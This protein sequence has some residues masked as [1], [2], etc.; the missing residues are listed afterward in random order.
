[1]DEFAIRKT[2]ADQL[3]K[4]IARNGWSICA[5]ADFMKI[6][7]NELSGILNQKKDVQLSTLSRIAAGVGRPITALICPDAAQHFDNAEII[8]RVYVDLGRLQKGGAA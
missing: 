8:R 1:M 2:L 7:R 6:S 4:I 3:F 5:A